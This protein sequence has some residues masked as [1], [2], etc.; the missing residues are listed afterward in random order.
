MTTAPDD[1]PEQ[2]PNEEDPEEPGIGAEAPSRTGPELVP[3]NPV[4]DA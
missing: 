4:E 1:E 2:V 3:P